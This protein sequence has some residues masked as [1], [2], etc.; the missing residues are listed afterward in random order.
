MK[1][2]LE[3]SLVVL[4]LTPNITSSAA[5]RSLRAAQEENTSFAGTWE[6][7][8][9]DPP[10]IT[11]K[12]QEPEGKIGDIAFYFPQ[13]DDPGGPW[14]VAGK[15]ARPLLAPY[16]EGNTLTLG[17]RHDRCR[18]CSEP[19][20]EV[21]FRMALAGL[22]EARLSDLNERA[23]SGSGLTLVGQTEA[24][25]GSAAAMKK[26][27][28]VELPVT[29]NAVPV[30]KADNED[31]LIVTITHDGSVY[32]GVNLIGAAELREKVKRALSDR[33]DKTLYIKADAQAPYGSLVKVLD[34]LRTAG[35]EGLTLLTGQRNVKEPGTLV[36]PKGLEM[37][38]ISRRPAR[39][40][41]RIEGR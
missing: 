3:V 34:S 8:T 4:A 20:R 21:K 7:R 25:G 39:S 10:G 12:I 22:N 37:L 31:S 14:H 27:I 40:A 18:R 13:C 38:V 1:H 26:G 16:V 17:V 33:A 5:T 6:G 41:S 30:P 32:F 35:V 36:S 29:S 23:D 11:V 28:A 19:G 2:A 24:R 15:S 9:N